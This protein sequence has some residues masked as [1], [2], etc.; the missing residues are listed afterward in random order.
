MRHY[1]IDL[2]TGPTSLVDPAQDSVLSG[3]RPHAPQT[4]LAYAEPWQCSAAI[5]VWLGG[6]RAHIAVAYTIDDRWAS[7]RDLPLAVFEP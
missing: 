3:L 1:A 6:V 4:N 7:R 2:Q 5:G